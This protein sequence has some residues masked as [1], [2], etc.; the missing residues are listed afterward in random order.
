MEK[1]KHSTQYLVFLLFSTLLNFLPYSWSKKAGRNLGL[2]FYYIDKRHRDV[3]IENLE[4]TFG[5]KATKNEIETIAKNCFQ[6][7][8]MSIVEIIRLEKFNQ[9]E[10]LKTISV[11][12]FS[13][14]RD[15]VKKG[16]GLVL[17]GAH[18][19]NW[20]L[21][22]IA[23]SLLFQ[24]GYMVA[25]KMDNPYLQNKI[26]KIR[27]STGNHVINK[28]DAFWEMIK[29]LK[30]GELV[31]LLMDQNVVKREGVFVPFF[32]RAACTNKGLAM[33]L[34]KTKTPMVPIFIIRQNDGSHRIVVKPEIPLVQTGNLKNDIRQNTANVN[35]AIEEIV[36]QYPDQWL[37][38]HRRWK[39]T[40]A[41]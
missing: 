13:N 7:L 31:C 18:F 5:S 11:E 26:D 36:R 4:S 34:L 16:K 1:I 37:W 22:G 29:L 28:N 21:L 24:K 25:R 39:T 32:G 41:E 19:G 10:F 2:F 23:I 15:A 3:T 40:N 12:G 35:L 14:Y 8:G 38:M 20:E 30:K 17:I 27:T 6:N 9:K 33:I